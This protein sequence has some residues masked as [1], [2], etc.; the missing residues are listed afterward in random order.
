MVVVQILAITVTIAFRGLLYFHSDPYNQKHAVMVDAHGDSG[1]N[2]NKPYLR[3]CHLIN[4]KYDR[5]NCTDLPLYKDDI[6][7][8]G[9]P[10]QITL[11][12]YNYYRDHVPDLKR[13]IALGEIHRD[14]I[15]EHPPADGVFAFVS[16]PSG[17]IT[18]SGAFPEE[19]TLKTKD[20]SPV[21]QCF[22]KYVV[23]TSQQHNPVL[24]VDHITAEGHPNKFEFFDIEDYDVIFVS[25]TSE[26]KHRHFPLFER[27]LTSA[28]KIGEPVDLSDGKC[29]QKAGTNKL[30]PEVQAALD[31]EE[32]RSPIGDCG[33]SGP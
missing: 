16:M 3:Q 24:I 18:T 5:S 6:V 1:H 13:F 33:P 23:L 17:E 21:N 11:D 26:D 27:L 15:N 31:D 12:P 28:G 29:D 2:H 14:V 10:G 19:V 8:I 20:N 7:V 9:S 25:N 4:G 30:K 32:I 22:A